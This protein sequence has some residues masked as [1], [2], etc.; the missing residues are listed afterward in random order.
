MKYALKGHPR[1]SKTTFMP[2]SFQ[3]IRLG[4]DFDENLYECKYHED[5]I[6]YAMEKF[7]DFLLLDLLTLLQP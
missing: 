7:C 3:H 5:I 1:S 6:S 4:T 2:K